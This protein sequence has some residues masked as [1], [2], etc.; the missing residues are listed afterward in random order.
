MKILHLLFA[1]AVLALA[2]CTT[3][4]ITRDGKTESS[5]KAKPPPMKDTPET[6][7]VTYHGKPGMEMIFESLLKKANFKGGLPTR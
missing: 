1:F 3:S 6:V 5:N 7:L 4:T 2:G